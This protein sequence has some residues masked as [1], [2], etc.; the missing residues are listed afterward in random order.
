MKYYAPQHCVQTHD[1]YTVQ[2]DHSI[3][4]EYNHTTL[5]TDT[6]HYLENPIKIHKPEFVYFSARELWDFTKAELVVK[7]GLIEEYVF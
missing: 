6:E 3:G 1:T 2:R 7:T 5:F 4:P